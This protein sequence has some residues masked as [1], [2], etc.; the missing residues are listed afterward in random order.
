MNPKVKRQERL[1]EQVA[2]FITK[3]IESA[4]FRPGDIF[5]PEAELVEMFGV[6]RAVIREALASLKHAGLLES[7]QG[8][9][10]KVADLE[11]QKS[12]R[13]ILN[14]ATKKMNLGYLYELRVALEGEAAALAA[15]RG[16]PEQI[17]KIKKCLDALEQAMSD[18]QSGTPE[19][20]AFH[21]ALTEAS[22]NPH[23]I[24][25]I[26]WMHS[27]IEEQIQA[28]REVSP[29]RKLPP[30]VQQEHTAIYEAIKSGDPLK[31]RRAT[32]THLKNSAM[33]FF[34]IDLPSAGL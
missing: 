2:D 21:K 32:I 9:R 24:H 1:A 8:G 23:I 15:V 29:D 3:E 13:L 19:N 22:S 20:L 25:F 31:A 11:N 4:S 27:R 12:F 16:T 10:T 26:N 7:R 14:P 17:V 18:G 33:K 30:L 6:S 34:G 28:G 5:P